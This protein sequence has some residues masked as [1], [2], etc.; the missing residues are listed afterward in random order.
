MLGL[1]IG[2]ALVW[3]LYAIIAKSTQ[4][5]HTDTAEIV[6]WTRE[7]ALGYPKHPP[8][9][10]WLVK[11]WF[12]IFPLTDWAYYLLAGLILGASL[13]LAFLL[14]GEWLDGV[15][16]AA[17]PFLLAVI[18]FYNFLRSQHCA[19]P[20]VGAHHLGLHALARHAAHRLGGA[21]RARSGGIHADQILV[22]IPAGR[23]VPGRIG[24]PQ[25]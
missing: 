23:A 7:L 6:V 19:D 15:K 12:T 13:Y 8:F 11:G 10:V 18:P 21:R 16:R 4:D 20:A 2:Y 24:R 3:T 9:T 25:A 14:A 1:A 5:L 17:V 22:D